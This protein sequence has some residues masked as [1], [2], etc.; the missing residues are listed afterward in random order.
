MGNNISLTY[1]MVE[2]DTKVYY[3][4]ATFREAQIYQLIHNE[5]LIDF[6]T[7][8]CFFV[9]ESYTTSLLYS[10]VIQQPQIFFQNSDHQPELQ[11][12][13]VT[14][15]YLVKD[16][17]TTV[18][19][20]DPKTLHYILFDDSTSPFHL[21]KA[22]KNLLSID[23]FSTRGSKGWPS[24]KAYEDKYKVLIDPGSGFALI[25]GATNYMNYELYGDD[26]SRVSFYELDYTIIK[27]LRE[28]LVKVNSTIQG[29]CQ[30]AEKFFHQEYMFFDPGDS[31][32]PDYE[33]PNS[34]LQKVTIATSYPKVKQ[35]FLKLMKIGK[36]RLS[37]LKTTYEQDL[38]YL[39]LQAMRLSEGEVVTHGLGDMLE[40]NIELQQ[41]IIHKEERLYK[42]NTLTYLVPYLSTLYK[43]RSKYNK[44]QEIFF[45]DN[46]VQCHLKVNCAEPFG[47]ERCQQNLKD[48]TD[49]MKLYVTLPNQHHKSNNVAD[50]AIWVARTIHK[51][52]QYEKHPWTEHIWQEFQN[53]TLMSAF[54]HDIGKIGDLDFHSL[55]TL[56]LKPD[57]PFKGYEFTLSKLLFKVLSK[58]QQV[59]HHNLLDYLGCTFN[60]VDV[61]V[62]AL[63]IALHHYFGQLLMTVDK[64]PLSKLHSTQNVNL[65]FSL[66]K[67]H[68]KISPRLHPDLITTL[69]NVN[70]KQVMF[71]HQ[72]LRYLKEVDHD[73]V[74]VGSPANL[75][76]L[77]HIIFAVSAA[78]TYGAF[79]VDL[80]ERPKDD[81][82]VLEP[83]FL[84]EPTSNPEVS[85]VIGR[86]FYK[87]LYHTI[88]LQQKYIFLLFISKVVN[89]PLFLNAWNNFNR[90]IGY[91]QRCLDNFITV[92]V[93]PYPYTR[94]RQDSLTVFLD[95]L[96]NLLELG[97]VNEQVMNQTLDPALGLELSCEL[98]GD[99]LDDLDDPLD[100]PLELSDIFEEDVLKANL[101]E[102]HIQRLDNNLT[103]EFK[104]DLLKVITYGDVQITLEKYM[105]NT[106]SLL[107]DINFSLLD[108]VHE[109]TLS[110]LNLKYL[111]DQTFSLHHV[112]YDKINY[113][114][115]LIQVMLTFTR[116]TIIYENITP[117]KGPLFNLLKTYQFDV[118]QTPPV[119]LLKPIIGTLTKDTN[120][121]TLHVRYCSLV[122]IHR[123]TRNLDQNIDQN[124]NGSQL[125]FF[126]VDQTQDD[127]VTLGASKLN[128][129]VHGSLEHK[130]FL[131]KISNSVFTSDDLIKVITSFI[132]GPTSTLKMFLFNQGGMW[133]LSPTTNFQGTLIMI[134]DL[135][136]YTTLNKI[137]SQ[138]K[139]WYSNHIQR[140]TNNFTFLDAINNLTCRD[141]KLSKVRIDTLFTVT[142][143]SWNVM[144]SDEGAH[145]PL[146]YKIDLGHNI[147]PLFIPTFKTNLLMKLLFQTT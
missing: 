23:I 103:L 101:N 46:K 131:F 138:V 18:Q 28:Y 53:I 116:A 133:T 100:D 19:L 69:D 117:D 107:A 75:V 78:D 122:L 14:H 7:S 139:L 105:T 126:E 119:R 115:D 47:F 98:D 9:T 16:R 127:Q 50:H 59:S 93:L 90:F 99:P 42:E 141:L 110:T 8:S 43:L 146:E 106:L 29:W 128:F 97:K 83:E 20:N 32:V 31:L 13:D 111:Q 130:T 88:G 118:E 36:D 48:L 109:T 55:Q 112:R 140:S 96:Y 70:F 77:V 144:S 44:L 76:Q 124:L 21:T 62:L 1:K 37:T 54:L 58:D 73:D 68:Y 41:E 63:V 102:Y 11:N 108:K 3:S 34:W 25:L 61:T 91:L 71:L 15:T 67:D 121:V 92:E 143:V 27:L 66:N 12:H 113:L 60:K 52:F 142:F 137:V 134:R 2:P 26:I 104:N 35:S 57:H 45:I 4:S 125:G 87:Y 136:D 30:P 85:V 82:G 145:L 40:A 72:L 65:P 132:Q 114:S 17:Q 64:I 6:P 94:L 56:E 135:V 79:P 38:S 39:K 22:N 80:P 147:G 95:D 33:N 24:L 49:Q 129:M 81:T 120:S 74:F 84:Y 5:P 51:W 89:L 123:L 10:K 86:P